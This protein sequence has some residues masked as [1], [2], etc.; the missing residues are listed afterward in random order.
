[1][2]KGVYILLLKNNECRILTGARGEISFSAGWHGYVGSA[3]GPGGLSRVLRHFRLNEKKDKRPRWHIDFLLL[4]PC[5]QVMRAYCIHTSE[6]I[7]CLL[8][9][10]MTGKVI[11]GFGST[12]CSCKGHLFYFADDPHEDILHLVSSI[13]EKEG[14]SSHT[15]ILVP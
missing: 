10:Q 7:E 14:P 3:L 6:K 2:D 5:F 15:D 8:A 13:S 4:S 12:D 9:M 1:M 11:S